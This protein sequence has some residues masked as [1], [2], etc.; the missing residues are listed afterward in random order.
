M[1]RRISLYLAY[2]SNQSIRQ[3]RHRCPNART[4]DTGVLKNWKLQ[5]KVHATIEPAE[6]YSVPVLIWSITPECEASLDAYEGYPHYYRKEYVKI[7]IGKSYRKAMVYIMND[8]QLCPPHRSYYNVI[9]DA[10]TSLGFDHGILRTALN[11]S[12]GEFQRNTL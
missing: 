8:R 2:G 12:A 7:R 5:F 9:S 10:Y 4:V 3:M 6:G 11:E 1:G